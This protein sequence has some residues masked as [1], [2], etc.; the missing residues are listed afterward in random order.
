MK[1]RMMIAVLAILPAAGALGQTTLYTND[2]ESGPLG[3]EWSSNSLLDQAPA[4]TQFNGR[5]S[6]GYT[7]L[8]LGQPT[9]GG[10][11]GSLVVPVE[12]TLS[13][14]F[15]AIDSW[16][17]NTAT[18]LAGLPVGPDWMDVRVNGQTLL[19]ETFSNISGRTQTFRPA[20]TGPAMLGYNES[21]NDSIFRSIQIQFAVPTDEPIVIRWTDLGLQGLP[22]ES[23]GIDNVSVSYAPVPA[24]GAAALLGA[25][26]L[27][28]A[29]RRRR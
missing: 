4:F 19:H 1:T 20:D 8:T 9:G 17:G 24:P 28:A 22:D 6:S 18:N 10:G 12:Y 2:F 15:F 25:A 16:D 23:W 21:F 11:T 26:A 29:R 7:E 13:F 3:P 27:A 5:Y 14:D